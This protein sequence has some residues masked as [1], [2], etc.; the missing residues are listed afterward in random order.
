METK[1][2]STKTFK[3]VHQEIENESLFVIKNHDTTR[4]KEKANFL[5]NLGFDNSIATKL[6]HAISDNK[7][8]IQEYAIKYPTYKF[9]LKPQLERICEKYN[10]YVRDPKFFLGDI[11]EKNIADM[12]N[13]KVYV[14]D[15]FEY[16]ETRRSSIA[17]S[18][19]PEQDRFEDIKISS[20][21]FNKTGV[22]RFI[23]IAAI[24]ELF[25]V[26]AFKQSKQRILG[27][28][29]L[30]PKHQVELDPIVLCETLHGYL[31][32]TAWGDEAN[33]ELVANQTFN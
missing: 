28:T 25:D 11:P 15:L 13:F 2:I 7:D 21:D 27:K 32:I 3:E 24:E 12:A 17:Y 22:S 20:N 29:E 19:L 1:S 10:L 5:S 4:F 16:S 8:I 33:D 23:K 31:I 6:Y 26:N 30:Q 14:S 18:I 9:I